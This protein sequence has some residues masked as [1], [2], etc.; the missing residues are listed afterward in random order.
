MA[1]PGARGPCLRTAHPSPLPPAAAGPSRMTTAPSRKSRTACLLARVATWGPRRWT[2]GCG[3]PAARTTAGGRSPSAG[4]SAA[5]AAPCV[6]LRLSGSVGR[7]EASRSRL[8]AD[9]EL[10]C[11]SVV[12]GVADS[13]E[14]APSGW[15][16][17]RERAVRPP[18]WMGVSR[19]TWRC[20][21]LGRADG[22][23]VRTSD[24]GFLCPLRAPLLGARHPLPRSLE[25]QSQAQAN[26]KQNNQEG[27]TAPSRVTCRLGSSTKR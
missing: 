17:G 27:G 12:R 14:M 7:S 25:R 10:L 9:C 26:L 5:A 23:L 19:A 6:W 4:R 13:P 24:H 15:D 20:V 3:A 22:S 21:T 16:P 2:A 11:P 8:P 18:C 1:A